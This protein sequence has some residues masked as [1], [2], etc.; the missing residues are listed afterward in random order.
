MK[1]LHRQIF[2]IAAGIVAVLVRLLAGPQLLESVYSRGIFLGI[3]VAFDYLFN[4]L[5]IA[6]IYLVVPL[7][8]GWTVWRVIRFFR[9]PPA[10]GERKWVSAVLGVVAFISGL[11]FLFLLLW[12]YNYGRVAVEDRLGLEL[13]PLTK[14]QLAGLV[15]EEAAQLAV[16]RATFAGGDTAALTDRHFPADM[17]S[18]LRESLENVLRNNGYPTAGRVRGRLLYPRG[19]FLRFGSAGMYFPFSG[20]GHVDA[21]LIA[22]QRPYTLA[23]ELAHG[24]GFGDEG[25][26]SFW[27]Y[28]AGL[29]SGDLAL[30]YATRLAYWRHLAGTY[31]FL[32][33]EAYA[34]LRERLAPGIRA[35][36]AAINANLEAYPDIM[37]A[38]RDAAY[39]AYLRSQGIAEGMLNYDRVML[40]VEAWRR[41]Q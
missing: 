20:E 26:C 29:A 31:R 18:R 27:G 5:P 32:Q 16:L 22:L 14:E 10:S 36:L 17:E 2:W 6:T 30:A 23:H 13:K 19:I 40:L 34:D 9:R 35:D 25:A 11:V 38:L 12:G 37:P 15:E 41:G 28:L 39:D 33:P 8:I 21:G 1:Q 4:W 3:R 7:F 24:Y